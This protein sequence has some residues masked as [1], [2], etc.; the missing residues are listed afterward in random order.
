MASTESSSDSNTFIDNQRSLTRL[1]RSIS[2]SQGQFSLVLVRCNYPNLKER[3]LQRLPEILAARSPILSPIRLLHLAPETTNLYRAVKLNLNQATPSYSALF[4]LGL[5]S[6]T[7]RQEL[8]VST[9]VIRDEFRKQLHCPLV[10]WANDTGL[11]HILQLAPDL[12]NFAANPIS[13]DLTTEEL[14]QLIG[15]KADTL[16]STLLSQES[17][18]LMA[19]PVSFLPPQSASGEYAKSGVA[20]YGSD[21]E[22]LEF[23]LQT[24]QQRESY[25]EPSLQANL[26]ML[27]GQDRLMQGNIDEAIAYYQQTLYYWQPQT[28]RGEEETT[29]AIVELSLDRKGLLLFYLGLCFARQ[30]QNNGGERELWE[31][32][33]FYFDRSIECFM[34]CDREDL[35]AQMTGQ[36]SDVLQ[37][38]QAWETL[39]EFTQ[40]SLELH[41]KFGSPV[42]LALDYG[43]LGKLAAETGEWEM[44]GKKLEECLRILASVDE[45]YRQEKRPVLIPQGLYYLLWSQLFRLLL[46]KCQGNLDRED[47][48]KE[49]LKQAKLELPRA[50]ACSYSRHDPHRYLRLLDGVRSLY[51]QEGCYREAFLLK[52]ES[53]AVQAQYGF[54]P[55]VG[56]AQLRPSQQALN[57]LLANVMQSEGNAGEVIGE[58]AEAIATSNRQ[59]DVQQLIYRISRADYKVTIIHGPSGV[60]KSS[61]V[62]AG[63]IPALQ[64]KTLG[65]RIPIPVVIRVYHDWIVTF[66]Q[67][68]TQALRLAGDREF[69]L[70]AFTTDVYLEHLR[71]TGDLNGLMILIFD[72]FEEFFFACSESQ[73]R[74]DFYRFLSECLRLPSVKV[75]FSIREDYLHHLLEIER[76]I[77]LDSIGCNL[78]DKANR[79]PL[80]NFGKDQTFETIKN[81]TQNTQF[82]LDD[83]L[84]SALVEDLSSGTNE[85]RPIELQIVGSQ[86]Q[87]NKIT[88]L[89]SYQ[90][91]GTKEQLVKDFLESVISDCGAE[92]Y[93]QARQIIYLFTDEEGTRPVKTKSEIMTEI[94]TELS[95]QQLSLIVDIFCDSGLIYLIP[96]EVESRYQLVHDYLVDF[97]QD[98]E[99]HVIRHERAELQKQNADNQRAIA[100]LRHE[101]QLI[102]KLAQERYK[103]VREDLEAY[104]PDSRSDHKISDLKS[105]NQEKKLLSQG[106]STIETLRQERQLLTA[107]AE[108]KERHRNSEYQRRRIINALLM[109]AGCAIL[110]LLGFT[111]NGIV[112]QIKSLGSSSE[113]FVDL[114]EEIEGLVRGIEAGNQLQD[115]VFFPQDIA[116]T[117]EQ[118]LSYSIYKVAEENRLEGHAD[119]VYSVDF[120][121][122]GRLIATAGE[123][124]TIRVWSSQGKHYFT[125]PAYKGHTDIVTSVAFSPDSQWLISA[126]WDKTIKLWN[127]KKFGDL[128]SVS[129]SDRLEYIELKGHKDKIISLVLSDNLE[130]PLIASTSR[131]KTVKIW[132]MDGS[133]VVTLRHEQ[134][135]LSASFSPDGKTIATASFDG[136]ICL[137]GLDGSLIK[138]FGSNQ[139][140]YSLDWS[141][142]GKLLAAAGQ[143]IQP[144][145]QTRQGTVSFW[146]RDGLVHQFN[147][148]NDKVLDIEFSPDGE[149]FA[150]TSRDKTIKI[151]SGRDGRL[152]RTLQGHRHWVPQASFSPDGRRIASASLDTTVKLWRWDRSLMKLWEVQGKMNGATRSPNGRRVAT[153]GDRGAIGIRKWNGKLLHQWKGHKGDVWG[154][155]FSP[156]GRQIVTGG[157]DRQIKI[158]DTNGRLLHELRGHRDV[159]L[160]VSYSP[161]GELIASGSKDGAVKLWRKD[162]TFV[163]TLFTDVSAINWIS[164][165]PDGQLIA[166]ASDD[167]RVKLWR[168]DGTQVA[169]L[170]HRGAV[171]GV[172]FSPD[173]QTIATAGLDSRVKLWNREGELLIKPLEHEGD[174]V[175]SVSFSPDGQTLASASDNTI[176]LWRRDGTLLHAL[177]GSS[178]RRIDAV[179]FSADGKGLISVSRDGIVVWDLEELQLDR[180]LETGCEWLA[181][182]LQNNPTGQQ[183][184]QLCDRHVPTR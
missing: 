152:Q 125:I 168:V 8:L 3:V 172:A 104:I 184:R 180:L 140:V 50:I 162:G 117:I 49:S 60:G 163:R 119:G 156:D 22:Q 9:N 44:A 143:T 88:T 130:N 90:N 144:G 84:I 43:F 30:G 25:L 166:A 128:N 29:E 116:Q 6:I 76:S 110:I 34:A 105:L 96:D 182:Y 27:L 121:P 131:D 97:I 109:G 98:N 161:D 54:R 89:E 132:R 153:I 95:E 122:D 11:T 56:A 42:Q 155:D 94:G 28:Y 179:E 133:E 147:A 177:T 32:A 159:V 74:Q 157:E 14:Q 39:L 61:T 114:H 148:H 55:F 2:L 142:D 86:L 41:Q 175:T 137:W 64:G 45:R 75:I 37:H 16:F 12:A 65:D 58:V 101:N 81:I 31:Q 83:D 36:V 72:Q 52:Q 21:R 178:D 1:A 48:A 111:W 80:G 181:G 154:V 126:S 141:K 139:E 91:F 33:R 93:R 68:L 120:S 170:P 18:Q 158:W 113:A 174:F 103:F 87:E 63:L 135:V 146:N 150:T 138:A 115:M 176:R 173:G 134:S 15:R 26:S 24:L 165:S 151:W 59:Q 70:S 171:W 35:I 46:V 85:V 118:N 167:A 19:F 82:E 78:L 4:V 77:A 129:D 112:T 17:K 67:A 66:G 71:N 145:T 20:S 102:S 10:L 62:S 99:N 160:S 38:L 149:H 73:E 108:A 40:K 23:A 127:L 51:F 53:R 123:D 124:K 136:R 5:E 100:D 57:P 69:E 183:Y 106:Q 79:Y 92:N 13:F 169:T 47:A 164:F 7:N 107:L